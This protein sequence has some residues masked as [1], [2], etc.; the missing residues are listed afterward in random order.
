MLIQDFMRNF[1]DEKYGR[2][3]FGKLG[4]KNLIQICLPRRH[5]M[6]IKNYHIV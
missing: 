4:G 6:R 2:N 1:F 5:W 3:K